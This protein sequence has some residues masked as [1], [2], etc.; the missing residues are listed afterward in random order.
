MAMVASDWHNMVAVLASLINYVLSRLIALILAVTY[1]IA[2]SKALLL[3][4]SIATDLLRSIG[5]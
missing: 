5:S 3:N 1:V 2:I 4:I